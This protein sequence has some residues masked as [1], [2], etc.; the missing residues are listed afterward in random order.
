MSGFWLIYDFF[1][2]WTRESW[3][4]MSRIS[5]STQFLIKSSDLYQGFPLGRGL[6]WTPLLLGS[7][8]CLSCP[9]LQSSCLKAPL[10][11]SRKPLFLL[12]FLIPFIKLWGSILAALSCLPGVSRSFLEVPIIGFLSAVV[13]DLQ[14]LWLICLPCTL[15]YPPGPICP[16]KPCYF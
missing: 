1:L 6:L 15:L 3:I 10:F 4:M 2:N 7:L 8:H 11:G 5:Y 9:F 16:H 13:T 14:E 12:L